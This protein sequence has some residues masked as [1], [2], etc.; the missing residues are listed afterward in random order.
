MRIR[1]WEIWIRLR[2][3]LRS[4]RFSRLRRLVAVGLLVLAAV[5][6]VR[7]PGAS[8]PS[9]EAASA[10]ASPGAVP[11]LVPGLSTV[12]VRLADAAVAG[13]LSPGTRVDVVTADEGVS[14]VLAPLATVVDVRSPPAG[15]SR[16]L[17]GEDKGP[18]VLIAVPPDTA[19][20]VAASSLRNPV[21]VTLR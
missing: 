2:S 15:S 18:L 5:F 14:R 10:R 8:P 1:L 17:A 16:F 20:Q 6:A 3:S 12:P 9:P 13:L 7:S 19:T 11:N 21:A 4:R